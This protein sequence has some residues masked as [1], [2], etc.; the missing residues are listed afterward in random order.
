M[1]DDEIV[2]SIEKQI[3]PAYLS[4]ASLILRENIG[5]YNSV[6]IKSPTTLYRNMVNG[7][8]SILFC[9]IKNTGNIRFVSFSQRYEKVRSW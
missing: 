6:L 7:N 4:G 1:S 8:K 5:T 9:R 2:L 3:D